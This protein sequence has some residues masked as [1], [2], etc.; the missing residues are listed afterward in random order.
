MLTHLLRFPL[1]LAFM[2]AAIVSPASAEDRPATQQI[3]EELDLAAAPQ[4]LLL[5][6]P[7]DR[8]SKRCTHLE[9]SDLRNEPV[10][11]YVCLA[12][13]ADIPGSPLWAQAVWKLKKSNRD[14][15]DILGF[16]FK[17]EWACGVGAESALNE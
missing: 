11:A 7:N 4:K 15:N 8:P 9:Q 12:A 3:R 10:R 17:I 14:E 6:I 1:L 16:D 5:Q 2:G 13:R